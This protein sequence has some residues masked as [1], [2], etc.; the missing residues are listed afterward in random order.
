ME[1]V[2]DDGAG[3]AVAAAAAA[4]ERRRWRRD[5]GSEEESDGSSGG[6]GLELSLRLRTGEDH[7]SGGA[8]PAPAPVQL[9]EERREQ[10]ARKRNMTIFYN[11][12]VCA[13]DVTEVQ[14]RAIISMASEEIR[15]QQDSGSSSGGTARRCARDG[16]VR[17]PVPAAVVASPAAA[18]PRQGGF[19]VAPVMDQAATGLSMKRS[20]QRFL[21]KR[22]ARTAA[23][24]APPYAGGGWQAQAMRH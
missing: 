21:Q 13:V 19:A 7:D 12:R 11:G 3:G 5:R 16:L 15:A 9:E 10:A 20:L 18:S 2:R 23:A 6:G 8:A 22:Q 24:V 4:A 14:A 17:P 1:G